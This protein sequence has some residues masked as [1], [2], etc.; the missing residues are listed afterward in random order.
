MDQ[1]RP[2]GLRPWGI[3]LG[4]KLRRTLVVLLAIVLALAAYQTIMSIAW[5]L[6]H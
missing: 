6:T 3:I 5:G 1:R 4:Y 2:E